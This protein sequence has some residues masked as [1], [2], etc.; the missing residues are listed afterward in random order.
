MK[1]IVHTMIIFT[2]IR[3]QPL[4][5]ADIADTIVMDKGIFEIRPRLPRTDTDTI[6]WNYYCIST[7]IVHVMSRVEM[8]TGGGECSL[9]G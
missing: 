7:M 4:R 6:I 9:H 1:S 2:D 3:G 5:R 8:W